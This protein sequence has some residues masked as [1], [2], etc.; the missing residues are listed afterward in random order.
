MAPWR[1]RY[2]P[3]Q[4]YCGVALVALA[5]SL[6]RVY[7][8]A[9]KQ[10]EQGSD[11]ASTGHASGPHSAR[12]RSLVLSYPILSC[13]ILSCPVLSWPVLACPGLHWSSRPVVLRRASQTLQ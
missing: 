13:P 2:A 9:R 5:R 11:H 10:R 6:A 7:V 3:R 1:W 12:T 8:R 4:Q